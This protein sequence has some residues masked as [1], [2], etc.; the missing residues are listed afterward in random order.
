M[1]GVGSQSEQQQRDMV[2]TLSSAPVPQVAFNSFLNTMT[3][4]EITS[5]ILF[6][7][8]PALTL[9]MSLPVAK[10][11]AMALLD[12]VGQYE[13]ATGTTV[14]TIAELSDRIGAYMAQEPAA[15][16]DGPP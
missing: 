4:S 8:R 6:G 16:G 10:S 14:G 13:K 7:P 15:A 12:I 11:Y 3:A 2:A 5:L 9:I 1:S